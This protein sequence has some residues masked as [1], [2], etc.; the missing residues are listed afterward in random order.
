MNNI[1]APSFYFFDYETFGTHPGLDRPC[2][3]A[4][5][6][7]D[8]ELNIIG[9][10]LVIYCQVPNDYLPAPEACLITGITPQL[11]NAKGLPEPEFIAKIHAELSQP[12]TCAVGYNNVRF[13][14]EVTRYTLYRN[15]FDPYAWSYANNNS[16]WDLLDVMRA[17]YALR[18]DGMVWPLK[19]DDSPSF[20]LEELA[21]ANG[22]EHTQA[23]DAMSDVYATIGLAKKLKTA[24]PR[25]FDYLFNHRKKNNLVPLV[26][27]VNLKPLLHISGM[28]S[29]WQGCASWVVPI[30]WHPHNPNAVVAIDLAKDVSVLF[31]LDAEALKTRLYTKHSDLGPNEL[32]VP[33][34]V[35]HLNKCPVL[36]EA[37]VLRP[38]DAERLGIDRAQCLA[39]LQALKADT[40]LREK[41]HALYA[42]PSPPIDNAN[43]DCALYAGFFDNADKAAMQI[44][45]ETKPENLPALELHFADQR[46]APLL[47]R[48]RARHY[49]NTLNEQEAQRWNYHRR[50]YFEQNLEVYLLRL[51]NLLEEHQDNQKKTAIL[52][53]LCR[54]VEQLLG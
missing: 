10:P 29:A 39:N 34:K 12:N 21:K 32:P 22:I 2:Q 52:T 24:Q 11:A 35:I 23:H 31:D 9:E 1:T 33:I 18:P 19:D 20:K 44:I 4:G 13:D 3:F 42:T 43:V 54:Y 41:I 47:F 27:I 30:A 25:L 6:R 46:I 49:P 38:E 48:Y 5:V 45:R 51:N 16:R 36:A 14:D 37:K 50:D 40:H 53:A 28:F 17:A 7:T 15:F 26:D 8:S